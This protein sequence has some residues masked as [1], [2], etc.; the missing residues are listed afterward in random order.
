MNVRVLAP[1][2][3]S[4]CHGKPLCMKYAG[5]I[6]HGVF[7]GSRFVCHGKPLWMKYTGRIC[8]GVFYGSRLVCDGASLLGATG[9]HD[10]RKSPASS[11]ISSCS[12]TLWSFSF[13]NV[14]S[15]G[16]SAIGSSS[17]LCN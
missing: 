3:N 15:K 8:H 1:V 12:L 11:Q 14:K 7:Y 2:N 6:C 9:R 17:A 5:R 4:H 13:S 10:G 16:A